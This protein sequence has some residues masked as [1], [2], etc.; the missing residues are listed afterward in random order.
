[1]YYARFTPFTNSGKDDKDY[2]DKDKDYHIRWLQPE[3]YNE[4]IRVK[5]S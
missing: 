5:I 1:M 4:F 2:K 3:G